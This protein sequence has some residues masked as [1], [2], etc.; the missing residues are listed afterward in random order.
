MFHRL[1]QLATGSL[2]I[3]TGLPGAGK[4]DLAA[5]TRPTGTLW[6]LDTEGA[7]STLR[8][9]PD[10]HPQLQVVQTLSLRQLLDALRVIKQQGQRGDT[11]G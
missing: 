6:L 8:G 9:K 4:S 5:S 11:A 7:A 2:F 10:I 3:L 1:D